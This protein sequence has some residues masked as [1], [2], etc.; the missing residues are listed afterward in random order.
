M[1]YKPTPDEALSS[2]VGT[3]GPGGG[4]VKARDFPIF[5]RK[6]NAKWLSRADHSRLRSCVVGM[7]LGVASAPQHGVD[8]T[9][10]RP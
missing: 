8:I 10:P 6:V 1:A 4:M 9:G 2:W 7:V 5:A 3:A